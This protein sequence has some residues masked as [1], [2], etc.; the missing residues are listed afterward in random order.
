MDI[1]E[2]GSGLACSIFGAGVAWQ[3]LKGKIESTK[4][5]ASTAMQQAD[6]ALARVEALRL[7]LANERTERVRVEGQ[8]KA[9]ERESQLR[10]EFRQQNAILD[11]QTA[12]L[13]AIAKRTGSVPAMRAA[14]APVPR[15]E[16]P[17]DPPAPLPPMRPKL[18]SRRGFGGE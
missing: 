15:E 14:R 10:E 3:A 11:V 16:P 5:A 9:I 1:V 4:I 13:D 17:S 2:I 7:E 18:P 8:V 12:Y 6:T